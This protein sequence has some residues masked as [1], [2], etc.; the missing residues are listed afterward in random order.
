MKDVLIDWATETQHSEYFFQTP[1]SDKQ[2]TVYQGQWWQTHLVSGAKIIRKSTVP[3]WRPIQVTGGGKIYVDTNEISDFCSQWIVFLDRCLR[4]ATRQVAY[5]IPPL[6]YS[7]SYSTEC[8]QDEF[9]HVLKCVEVSALKMLSA[10]E[11][12]SKKANQFRLFFFLW[13]RENKIRIATP[14]FQQSV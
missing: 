11:R 5:F 12:F 2:L 13:E 4:C 10:Q 14:A 7:R 6:V 9:T 1:L 8:S 3:C